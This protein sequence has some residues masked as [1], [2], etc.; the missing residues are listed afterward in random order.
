MGGTCCSNNA[1][2]DGE[3]KTPANYKEFEHTA[4]ELKRIVKL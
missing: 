3:I 2:E 4:L 1:N